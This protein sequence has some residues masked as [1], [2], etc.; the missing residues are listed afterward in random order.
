MSRG[1]G[2]APWTGN[3]KWERMNRTDAPSFVIAR[4]VAAGFAFYATARHPYNFYTLTRWVVFLTCCW[5]LWL[6]LSRF[7]KSAAP[8][9]L[10]VALVF[11]PLLPFHFAR[12]TWQILDVAAGVI[13]LASLL[14]RHP[15]S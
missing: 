11:N 12:S 10:V 3:R 13:L 14:T 6:C 7:W 2:G 8:A 4:C 1:D 15:S 9:Y 5:G